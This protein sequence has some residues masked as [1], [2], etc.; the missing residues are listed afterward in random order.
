M[1]DLTKKI[2]GGYRFTDTKELL[3]V[4]ESMPREELY[5]VCHELTRE[6]MGDGFDTCSIINVKGG[7]CPEDCAWCTQSAHYKTESETHGVL[8]METVRD[9]ALYNERQGIGRFSLVAS[10]KRPNAREIAAYAEM[11]REIK[12]KG[13]IHLCA[14][15]GLATKEQLQTLKDAGCTTY[16]CNMESAP[17]HFGK[18]VTTHTQADKEETIR[19]AREVGMRACSGGIIGMG[20]T[21]EQRAEFALYLASLGIS[22]IPINFLHPMPGTPLGDRSPLDDEELLFAVCLFRL[23]NPAAFLRF[24]GGRALY[25]EATQ[26]KALY[27]GMNA[28][29][30]GDLLTTKASVTERDMKLFGEAGYDVKEET[31]WER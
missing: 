11:F 24:S 7:N 15:L 31:T 26:R 1:K 19:C 20:E 6:M 5:E 25:S 8:P 17:S 30:T 27:I 12:A 29:I 3:A 4:A 9:Q 22:S 16:H 18:L 21:R 13:G 23:A 10:G 14:S 2:L 28:A